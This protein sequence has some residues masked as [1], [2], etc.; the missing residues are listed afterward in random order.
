MA[1]FGSNL[2][3]KG[4]P[5][6]HDTAEV[7]SEYS[8]GINSPYHRAANPMRPASVHEP[9]NEL[10]EEA[11]LDLGLFSSHGIPGFGQRSQPL[12]ASNSET[13]NLAWPF[14]KPKNLQTPGKPF[15]RARQL[16]QTWDRK[17]I[18]GKR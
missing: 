2:S 5:Q 17:L 3:S 18:W 15:S 12:P 4:L 7:H 13:I 16:E 14:A 9:F 6:M 11:G 1:G 10:R 8:G